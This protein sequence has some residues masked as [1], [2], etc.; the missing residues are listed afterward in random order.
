MSFNSFIRSLSIIIQVEI[1]EVVLSKEFLNVFGII[2]RWIKTT[3]DM[4]MIW[5]KNI[6]FRQ[7]IQ[8]SL[9]IVFEEIPKEDRVWSNIRFNNP[10]V[11]FRPRTGTIM[12]DTNQIVSSI[13][14]SKKC[15]ARTS[16][17]KDEKIR[18][19]MK[20]NRS[21]VE[22]IVKRFNY[23]LWIW[24]RIWF[25]YGYKVTYHLFFQSLW[26]VIA[27]SWCKDYLVSGF[28]FR[29]NLDIQIICILCK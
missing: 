8:S 6:Q 11:N 18:L 1:N 21:D 16:L 5:V 27:C 2:S 24:F 29:V 17:T 10:I 25:W 28:K 19:H 26:L 3:N 4:L 9:L 13:T 23:H 22:N 15:F 7:S 12:W 20:N 14:M